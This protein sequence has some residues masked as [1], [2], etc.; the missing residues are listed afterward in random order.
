MSQDFASML[1]ES[2]TEDVMDVDTSF[3]DAYRRG[4]SE[5]LEEEQERAEQAERGGSG[6]GSAAEAGD[7]GGAS[8]D[9]EPDY[10]SEAEDIELDASDDVDDSLDDAALPEPTPSSA[11]DA[12]DLTP[13]SLRLTDHQDAAQAASSSTSSS[14]GGDGGDDDG[15]SAVLP[16]ARLRLDGAARQP[17]IKSLPDS[18]IDVLREQLRSAA[19]RE[20]GVDDRAARGFVEKLS[21][22]TMVTAFLIAH[23]DLRLGA[24]AATERA[25]ELFRS[26]DPLLGSVVARMQGLEAREEEQAGLLKALSAQLAEVRETSAVVEQALAYS[27]ADRAENFLRG[28]HNSAE[29][30]IGHKAAVAVRDRAREATKKQTR[31]ERERDGRPIR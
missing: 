6:G 25:A 14:R 21:Q 3:L 17:N 2:S 31:I 29:A 19:V 18:I 22:G 20:L 28:S 11:D 13:A 8:V 27:I 12:E 26:R 15:G 4:G 7:P 23:L 30:P 9:A 1:G 24:D 10:G 16:R 5:A